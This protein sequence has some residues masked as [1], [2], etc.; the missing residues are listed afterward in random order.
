MEKRSVNY[1]LIVIFFLSY[2]TYVRS[3]GEY[4]K[5]GSFLRPG[6]PGPWVQQTHGQVWPKPK[7]IK[8]AGQNFSVV[9]AAEFT[10]E[11]NYPLHS[12]EYIFSALRQRLLQLLLTPELLIKRPFQRSQLNSKFGG[13]KTFLFIFF[14]QQSVK[15]FR[16]RRSFKERRIFGKKCYE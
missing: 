3:Q 9:S 13:R 10:F 7:S 8:V 12:Y 1:I 2:P 4:F 16:R 6:K 11:V 14:P 5:T 15:Q